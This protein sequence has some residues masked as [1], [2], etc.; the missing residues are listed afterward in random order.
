MF[1]SDIINIDKALTKYYILIQICIPN[2]HDDAWL[3]PYFVEGLIAFL[4]LQARVLLS[5]LL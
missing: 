4:V 2:S 1:S 5:V 3:Y